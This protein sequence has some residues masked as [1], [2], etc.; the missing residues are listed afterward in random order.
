MNTFS[1]RALISPPAIAPSVSVPCSAVFDS[2]EPVTLPFV[3][4]IVGRLKPPGDNV[5]PR[6]LK[7]VFIRLLDHHLLQ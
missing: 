5:P 2:F 4:D 1:A 3:Q 6:L 7:E